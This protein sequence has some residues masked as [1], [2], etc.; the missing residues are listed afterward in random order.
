MKEDF[1]YETSVS[2]KPKPRKTRVLSWE[3]DED[4]S[5]LQEARIRVY[6]KVEL[7]R[8]YFPTDTPHTACNHLRR[9]ILRCPPLRQSLQELH[10]SPSKRFYRPKVVECIF[11]HL[12]RP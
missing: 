6:S 11:Q 1:N 2:E 12:G 4:Y 8:L 10:L 5:D 9:W 7:A 3:D